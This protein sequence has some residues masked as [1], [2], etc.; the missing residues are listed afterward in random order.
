MTKDKPAYNL[1]S[2]S[3]CVLPETMKHYLSSSLTEQ[4]KEMVQQ[5]LIACELCQ[6]ALEGLELL[7]DKNKLE[8]IVSEINQNLRQNLQTQQSSK[9][10]KITNR[11]FYYSATDS[12]I[13]LLGLIFYFN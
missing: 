7:S 12:I 5:H 3:G 8:A 6:D 10:I 2:P 4:E 11:V 1:F 13:I 9:K